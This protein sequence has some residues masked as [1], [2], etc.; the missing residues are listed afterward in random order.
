[1][2]KGIVYIVGAGPGDPDLITLKAYKVLKEADVIL[3]DRLVSKELLDEF[4]AEKVYVGRSIGDD[5]KHQDHTNMLMLRYAREG[6]KVV[7]LKGGDPFIFGRGGEELEFLKENNVRFEVIS[8]I[9]SAIAAAARAFIPLTHRRYSSSLAIVTGHEDA[10]KE[11]SSIDWEG[12]AKSIDTIVLFMAISNIEQ[13]SKRL[14]DGGLSK[15]TSVAIVEKAT[16]KDERILFSTLGEVSNVIKEH[17]IRP[18]AII[19]IGKVVDIGKRLKHDDS[20]N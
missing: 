18:P 15:D 16:L 19:I 13:I 17:N 14:I 4:D 10:A 3:Y 9:S 6:K 5:Y 20:N 1:M 7:R 12:I 2:S 11:C 8:G